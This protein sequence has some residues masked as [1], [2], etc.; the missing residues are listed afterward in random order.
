MRIFLALSVTP[1]VA[2]ALQKG[3]QRLEKFAPNARWT[4]LDSFHITLSF[5]GE[6]SPERL[7]AVERA[8]LKTTEG[9]KSFRVE[10]KDVGAFSSARADRVIW[11]G[12]S[13]GKAE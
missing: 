3:Q 5:L 11:S 4:G 13:E 6:V 8:A 12:V 1:E 7:A 2:G 10:L 9:Q